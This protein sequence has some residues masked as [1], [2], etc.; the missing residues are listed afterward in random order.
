[1]T[2]VNKE[3][4]ELRGQLLA[5]QGRGHEAAAEVA[6]LGRRKEAELAALGASAKGGAVAES[7]AALLPEDTLKKE[8]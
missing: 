1:V 5:L 2:Q 8:L 3:K 7:V 6:L 4:H